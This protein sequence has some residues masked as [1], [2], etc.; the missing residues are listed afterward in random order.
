MRK[1]MNPE[2]RPLAVGEKAAAA[3]LDM[4][5][6]DFW[7]LVS[8]GALPGP[9]IIGDHKRWVVSDLEAILSGDAARPEQAFT[10]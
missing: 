6:R 10:V 2:L 8:C 7:D 3:M 5:S 4:S 1:G 9:K